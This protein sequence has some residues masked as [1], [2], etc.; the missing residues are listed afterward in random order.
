MRIRLTDLA[1]KKL[2]LPVSGQVTH[3]DLTTPGF[4]LRCST[5]SKSYVVMFGEK[6]RLKTLGRHPALSLA[7]ARKRARALL[8]AQSD[9]KGVPLDHDYKEVLDEYLQDCHRRLRESTL[10]GYEL[11]LNSIQFSGPVSD[12]KQIDVLRAIERHTSSPSSQNYAFTTFKVF[13]NWLVRRQ[14]I[15]SNPLA[16][17]KRPNKTYA[18]NRDKDESCS[19]IVVEVGFFSS[20]LEGDPSRVSV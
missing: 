6:R 12:I 10:S 16:A 8:I 9:P 1:I 3:W 2:A 7:D 19:Q 18:K 15:A 13:F 14:Y 5:R 17:L 20:L 4:G 11:Y